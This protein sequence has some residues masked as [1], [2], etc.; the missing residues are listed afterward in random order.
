MTKKKVTAPL[1][2]NP[3]KGRPKEHLAYLNYQEMQALQ[4]LNGEGPY[5]GPKG[6]PS[7]VLGGATT[8]GTAA[9]RAMSSAAQS[10]RA[11]ASKPS[12]SSSVSRISGGTAGSN[13]ARASSSGRPSGSGFSGIGSGG[14]GGRDSGQA[15]NRPSS[16]PSRPSDSGGGGGRDSGQAANRPTSSSVSR[17]SGGVAGS[18]RDSNVI[19][20]AQ[21]SNTRSAEKTPALRSDTQRTVNVGPM[22]T[23]VNV[24]PGGAPIRPSA[25]RPPVSTPMSTQGPSFGSPLD[26][27]IANR[28]AINDFKLQSGALGPEGVPSVSQ[29]ASE[30]A[31]RLNAAR[32][33]QQYSQYRSPPGVPPA[34]PQG[35]FGPRAGAGTGYLR[36]V[37][38]PGMIT[39]GMPSAL[40]EMPRPRVNAEATLRAYEEEKRISNAKQITDR[41]PASKLYSG[42][43]VPAEPRLSAGRSAVVP[44]YP[45]GPS[46]RPFVVTDPRVS[47]SPGTY[48]GAPMDKPRLTVGRSAVVPTYPTTAPR[49]DPSLLRAYQ[50][51]F[52]PELMGAAGSEIERNLLA[53]DPSRLAAYKGGFGPE[54]MGAAGSELERDLLTEY[55]RNLQKAGVPSLGRTRG[56]P[57]PEERI[58]EIED[59]PLPFS[60]AGVRKSVPGF[61]AMGGIE[62]ADGRKLFTDP[63]ADRVIG[64]ATGPMGSVVTTVP[65]GTVAFK[66]A[67]EIAPPPAISRGIED[68]ND[69]VPVEAIQF[70]QV[71]PE[72]GRPRAS[73]PEAV[74]DLRRRGAG[75]YTASYDIPA[76]EAVRRVGTPGTTLPKDPFNV[77]WGGFRS[78]IQGQI[79][80]GYKRLSGKELSGEGENTSAGAPGDET[81]AY[82]T[83]DA[84]RGAAIYPRPVDEETQKIMKQQAL[85]NKI[86]TRVIKSRNP[87]AQ[88]GDALLKL[89]TGKNMAQQTESLKRQY[90]Q[91]SPEQQADLER[92]Y[93]NLTRFAADVGLTPQLDMSNYTQ[94]ADRAGLRAPPTR[95][96]GPSAA[97]SSGIG[98]LGGGEGGGQTTPPGT[99]PSTPTTPSTPSGRR[100]DIYYMWDLGVNIPSPGDPNY[101]LYQKYLVETLAAQQAAGYV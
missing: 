39:T 5:K 58:L 15:A 80:E 62:T 57:T 37:E 26:A 56:I 100:P 45:V 55:E 4:R 47:L 74:N 98:S 84:D 24:R 19:R 46:T 59:V 89:F 40:S 68:L 41:I 3:G 92:R 95:E 7:F 29:I 86:G 90:L 36:T 42:D 69:G 18:N 91:S 71:D 65:G 49:P 61:V 21:L 34:A 13:A 30:N 32:M 44:S 27:R 10:N 85:I 33:A 35:V 25:P 81:P 79:M 96:G 1:T 12:G 99:P 77:D 53:R 22:G 31:R 43:R 88:A 78:D 6:I 28:F 76:E 54:L 14:G 60:D 16:S 51:G 52:G 50:G 87:F 67:G 20:Q 82:D 94:W 11:S 2:Y 101:T 63:F 66:S 23:P 38:A 97:A 64:S 73:S 70:S 48:A 8:S 75:T 72:T 17:I 83:A 93:P 9:N